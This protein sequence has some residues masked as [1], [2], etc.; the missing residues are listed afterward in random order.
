MIS[1][2]TLFSFLLALM[3]GMGIWMGTD[4]QQDNCSRFLAGDKTAPSSEW[5]I[6]GTRQIVVPCNDWFARQ[7][8]RV[9]V[10]CLVDLVLSVVFVLNALADMRDWLEM[11]RRL[12]KA[13]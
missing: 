5:V 3:L 12:R 9:Q 10:L 11:R 7:S 8:T 6:S 13:R 4:G 1:R 2:V